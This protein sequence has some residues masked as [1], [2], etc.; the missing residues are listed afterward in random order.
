M[1]KANCRTGVLPAL[2][3]RTSLLVAITWVH[4]LMLQ[5]VVF[6]MDCKYFFDSLHSPSS[7]ESK[8]GT[9]IRAYKNAVTL[10]SNSSLSLIP[11]QVVRNAMDNSGLRGPDLLK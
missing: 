2:E 3:A 1:E 5:N 6:K 4:D 10:I 11:R 7:M 8:L 9:V